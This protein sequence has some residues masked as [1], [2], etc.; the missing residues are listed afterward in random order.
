MSA[1]ASADLM[2]Q[3]WARCRARGEKPKPVHAVIAGAKSATPGAIIAW[4]L[5][6]AY[7]E[8]RLAALPIGSGAEIQLVQQEEVG[9]CA[10]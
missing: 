9:A 8:N 5:N 2:R 1:H 4:G 6:L 10:T 7:V 3:Y